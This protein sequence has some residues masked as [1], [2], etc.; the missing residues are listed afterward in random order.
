MLPRRSAGRCRRRAV[1]APAR[2]AYGYPMPNKTEE[3]SMRISRRKF[4]E[5]GAVGIGAGF[6]PRV[7]LAWAQPPASAAPSFALVQP[8]LF[9]ATGAQ[10]NCW[11]DFDNDG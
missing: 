11:G 3:R 8:E 1:E 10:P 4:V 5:F 2:D 9:A 6:A 7:M